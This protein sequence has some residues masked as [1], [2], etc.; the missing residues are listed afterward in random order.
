M[1]CLSKN[2]AYAC[3][4]TVTTEHVCDDSAS[5]LFYIEGGSA[6][7]SGSGA[8]SLLAGTEEQGVALWDAAAS[9]MSNPLSIENGSSGTFSLGGVYVPN[10]EVYVSGA[11]V[12]DSS[13]VAAYTVDVA[14]SGHLTV[15]S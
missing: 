5:A 13:F 2:S 9:D 14:N 4:G 7:I 8:V 12:L 10:G 15:G 3:T 6:T 1:A 11:G